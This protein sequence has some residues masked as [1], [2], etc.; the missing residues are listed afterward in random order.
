MVIVGGSDSQP[1]GRVA[2]R[3]GVGW[4]VDIPNRP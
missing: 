4:V 3:N 1:R 2:G